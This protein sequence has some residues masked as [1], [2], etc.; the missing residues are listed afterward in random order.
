[1]RH[2]RIDD[3]DRVDYYTPSTA[4]FHDFCADIVD[5]YKLGDLIM[6]AK[7]DN[8]DYGD[9]GGLTSTEGF[10]LTTDKGAIFSKIVVLAV[11]PGYKPSIP[12][13]SNLCLDN[14][15]GS[16]CHCFDGS[17]GQHCL[18]E[19]VLRKIVRGH[20]TSVVVVGGGLTSAQIADLVI[21]R[22][23]TKVWLLLRGKYKLKHFDVDLE[24]VSKVRN[25]QMAVFWSAVSDEGRVELLSQNRNWSMTVTL[26]ERFELLSQARDGGS[27]TP[28]FDKIL[29]RHAATDRLSVL[30]HTHITDGDWCS[31]SQTWSL[32]LSPMLETS[33][34]CID[35][36]IYA[37]G[38]APN[39]EK[40]AC[41]QQMMAKW[42]VPAIAG[43][44][45]LTDDLMWHEDVPLF[46]TGGLAGLRLGPGAANLAGARQGAERIAWKVED[47]LGEGQSSSTDEDGSAL[48]TMDGRRHGQRE[49][50]F[51]VEGR[52]EYTGGFVN[53]FET[54]AMDDTT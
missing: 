30:T 34:T 19:H 44:P 53:Q 27:I 18:P 20:H 7:V 33:P 40:V 28:K 11:G 2:L 24:W 5:R 25:Q 9:L 10:T 49:S 6:Q 32:G 36:V 38:A 21:R 12:L 1:M 15:Q 41:M 13:D 29:K 51:S 16:V 26:A 50:R 52:S 43:L 8:I 22:G 39:I 3:R 45:R 46:L 42:P 17:V 23:V 37:T 48:G 54:L 14:G 35:H 4:V 47:L 31:H